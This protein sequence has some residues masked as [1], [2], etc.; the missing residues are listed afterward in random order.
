MVSPFALVLGNIQTI[1]EDPMKTFNLGCLVKILAVIALIAG[2]IFILQ[3]C[4]SSSG[5]ACQA[6]DK[7]LPDITAAPYSVTTPTH[8]YYAVKATANADGSVTM[9]GW[10]ENLDGN[11][12]LHDEE[13]LL[14]KVLKPVVK[15]R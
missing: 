9:N 11:W 4:S 8:L 3:T 5:C 14:P 15:R 1:L 6:I 13:I 12:T 7:T 2:V 10:Y